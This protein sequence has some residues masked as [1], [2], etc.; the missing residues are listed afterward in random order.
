L[1]LGLLLGGCAVLEQRLLDTPT[2]PTP[3]SAATTVEQA[4]GLAAEGRWMAAVRSLEAARRY[5]PEDPVLTAAL[6]EIESGRAAAERQLDD[7]L[8]VA[9]AEHARRK[10]ELLE[11]LAA[12]QAQPESLLTLSRRLFLEEVQQGRLQELVACAQ[13]QVAQDPALARRCLDQASALAADDKAAASLETVAEQLRV[14]EADVEQR[15]LAEQ[16][17]ARQRRARALLDDARTAIDRH[18]YRDALDLLDEVERLQPGDR[19]MAGLRD[20]AQAMLS[21]QIDALVRL[22]DHL[23]L[24]EQ[25]EAAVVTWQAALALMPGDEEIK[26]RIERARTVLNRLEDLRR[27]QKAGTG[28]D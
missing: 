28:G 17:R 19:E 3:A 26:A 20:Q 7:R 2:E 25:L 12:V 16:R 21:P 18:D 24:D 6:V 4:R 5:H 23:Y 15:R 9:E 22:G 10:I 27:Q 11:R 14:T 8:L 13:A 1:L